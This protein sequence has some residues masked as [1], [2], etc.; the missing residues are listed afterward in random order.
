MVHH[1]IEHQ[2]EDKGLTFSDFL[3]MHYTQG[4]VVDD[5]HAKD[6]KLPFKTNHAN[7][8]ASFVALEVLFDEI[9]INQLESDISF[10]HLTYAIPLIFTSS[11]FQPPKA[12]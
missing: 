11:V 2:S 9:N 6:M 5:D 10:A 3:V 8:F 7:I 1:F 4:N 12:A